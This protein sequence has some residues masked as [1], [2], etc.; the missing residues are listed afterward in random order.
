[1]IEIVGANEGQEFEAAVH[2]RK[3]ILAVWPDLSQHPDDHVKLFVSLKLYGQKYEDIDVFVVG[4]FAEPREF[5]VELKFYP[6]DSEPILPKRAY[7]RSFALAVE[8]KSHDATGVRFDDKLVSVKYPRGWECVTE[9]AFKQVFE[10]KSYLVRA[11]L[12]N[13]YVQ[14]LIFMSGLRETDLPVRPHNCFGIDASF[15]KILNI[16]GQVSQP[17]VKNRFVTISFGSD[18]NFRAILSPQATVLKTLEPTALDRKRMDRIVKSAL[19]DEWLDDLNKKQIVIRGRGGVGKTVILLQMAYRAFDNAGMRSLVL[20]YNKALVADMR[21]T[22]ALLGV[23][24]HLSK[25]G[26]GI[27]TVHAFL[28]RLMRELG[29]IGSE[30]DFLANYEKHKQGLL[31]YL[32]SGAVSKVD[33]KNLIEEN[34]DEFAWD[35]IFVDEGQDWPSN[36]IEILRTVF[37]PEQIVVADGVDQYVRDSVADWDAGLSRDLLRPRRLRRC[38]RMKANLAHFVADCAGALGLENWDLEPNPD[39]NGGRVIIVEGEMAG[40]TVIYE[41]LK[42]EAAELGNYPVDLLA[43]VPPTLVVHE[44]DQTYAIPGRAIQKAGGL[45]WDASSTD[46]RENYPT[47]RDALR[48]VQYDSCRGLE[49]WTVINYAFDDFYDYKLKQW[50]SSPP[51]LGGLFDTKEDLAAEFAAQ[52]VMIPITRAMDTLVI[53]LSKRSSR[54]KDALRQVHERRSD[55]VEWLE[56]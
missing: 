38:L 13:P 45:V 22:M 2:L 23:P 35:V 41:R 8:V 55:F 21:R 4:H 26:I 15:E 10:L 43:C 25:G 3:L 42:E 50:L 34:A 51:D 30:D 33:L 11:G 1:M 54:L 24:R 37:R 20:T 53:N 17:A 48:I 16:V 29:I 12:P 7:I 47:E 18:E 52:W 28:G 9:K 36:E 49:G 32:R 19:P 56:L 46:V 14:D 6:R 31:D 5:D 40:N 39:A 27:E 44:E